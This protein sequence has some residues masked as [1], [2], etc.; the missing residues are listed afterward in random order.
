MKDRAL[1]IRAQ[2]ITKRFNRLTLFKDIQVSLEMGQSLAITGPNGSGKSTLLEIIAGVR[3]P[4]SGDIQYL[5]DDE[6]IDNKKIMDYS[7]FQ[8]PRINP[9]IELSGYENVQFVSGSRIDHPALMD[10]FKRIGLFDHRNK[11]VKFYSSGMK[12]RLRILLAILRDPPILFL[13]EPGTNLDDSGKRVVFSYLK[14]V[15]KSKIVLIATNEESEAT[16]CGMRIH[17]GK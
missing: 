2:G 15:M 8:S 1:L 13:D 6:R 9:Y 3:A 4:T 14:S 7:G 5:I 12:Q 17:L 11:K 10:L 16:L